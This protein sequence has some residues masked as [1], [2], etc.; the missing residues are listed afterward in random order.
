MT[1][2]AYTSACQ[3]GRQWI[4][5]VFW[6]AIFWNVCWHHLPMNPRL[7][8]Q[9]FLCGQEETEVKPIIVVLEYS[10][11]LPSVR[12][13][14]PLLIMWYSLR[15][16]ILLWRDLPQ[17]NLYGIDF[18]RGMQ[19]LDYIIP[20]KSSR[21]AEIFFHPPRV[22]VRQ[23]MPFSSALLVMALSCH[24]LTHREGW[25]IQQLLLSSSWPPFGLCAVKTG[26]GLHSRYPEVLS[27]VQRPFPAPGPPAQGSLYVCL[28]H[29]LRTM[30]HSFPFSLLTSCVTHNLGG[31]TVDL[32]LAGSVFSE[33]HISTSC[34]HP[35]H[36]FSQNVPTTL[37]VWQHLY[38][39]Y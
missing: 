7:S 10:S 36:V 3:V 37:P 18:G 31:T 32:K 9:H 35:G 14:S 6:Q 38:F 4:L 5:H 1:R 33:L 29:W 39:V 15:F 11:F 12:L 30:V 23:S 25:A 28:A 24:C 19:D 34:R 17:S 2:F 16:I 27:G 13:P 22:E 8:V 26:P 20:Q 21:D